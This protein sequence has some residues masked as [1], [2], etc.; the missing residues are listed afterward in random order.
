MNRRHFISSSIAAAASTGIAFADPKQKRRVA[1]IGHTGR[2]NYGHGLDTVWLDFPQVEIV[3]LADAN[4]DGL[5]A[6]V[7]KLKLA[8]NSAF[9]DYRKMLVET[10]PEFVSVAPRHADQHREMCLAAI[11]AGA[12]GIY[13]EK[14]FL[15]SPKDCDEVLAAADKAGTKI[16]VAH[17]NRYHPT[18]QVIDE[19]INKGGLGKLLEI[20]GRGKGD[21][22][23]GAEDLW[24]LGTHVLNIMEYFGGAPKSCSAI[25][26]KDGR[27]ITKADVVLESKEGLGP[28]AG[29]ELHA[30]FEMERGVI[31]TFDSLADDDTN[32]HGFGVFLVGSKGMINLQM[33][34]NPIAHFLVGNPFEPNRNPTAW[35][36]ITTAGVGE[37]ETQ[38]EV[39]AAVGNHVAA[40]RDLIE[41]V[42]SEGRM[43]LCDGKSAALTVEMVCAIFASQRQ[44]GQA[45]TFP[46]Q[47]RENALALIGR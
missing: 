41:S 3:G 39:V 42:D 46:L 35:V 30:R 14:P 33:D 44:N 27:Q 38:A 16:A 43:P 10:K 2:G 1:I 31:G 4:A 17:R 28:L 23:G 21:R 26:L 25:M 22:R 29:N 18:L 9:A 7:T 5:A 36:P 40:V 34:K 12:R 8:D 19:L 13:V 15:Q 32:N 24:V 11:E 45:V 6:E 20:R 37:P 47:Q